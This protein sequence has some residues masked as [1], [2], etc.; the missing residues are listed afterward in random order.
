M[1]EIIHTYSSGG[2]TYKT[3]RDNNGTLSRNGSEIRSTEK[4]RE[5]IVGRTRQR[6]YLCEEPDCYKNAK[7]GSSCREHAQGGV[8]PKQKQAGPED[9]WAQFRNPSS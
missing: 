7:F 8:A 5:Y 4:G 3:V 9:P 2:L 1:A 6:K